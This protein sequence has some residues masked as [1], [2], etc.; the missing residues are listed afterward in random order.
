MGGG[1]DIVFYKDNLIEL[2]SV[3]SKVHWVATGQNK[4]KKQKKRKYLLIKQGTLGK[5]NRR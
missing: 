3:S 5:E 2:C 1:G 4:N